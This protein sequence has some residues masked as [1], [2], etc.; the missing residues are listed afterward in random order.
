[1]LLGTEQAYA[2][3][4]ALNFLSKTATGGFFIITGAAGTGKSFLISRLYD[5]LAHAGAAVTVIAPTGKAA[6]NLREKNSNLR[7]MTLHSLLYYVEEVHT[8][9]LDDFGQ[10]VYAPD[11]TKITI[12]KRQFKKRDVDSIRSEVDMIIMDEASMLQLSNA[13][14]LAQLNIPVVLFGDKEQLPPFGEEDFSILS[15]TPDVHLIDVRRTTMDNAI[16]KLAYVIIETGS[17]FVHDYGHEVEFLSHEEFDVQFLKDNKVDAIL[18]H[19]NAKRKEANDMARAA[20]GLYRDDLPKLGETIMCL[21]NHSFPM[22]KNAYVYMSNGQ[23]VEC[24]QDAGDCGGKVRLYLPKNVVVTIDK[25]KFYED[26][27]YE[28]DDKHC[29]C[30]G[31]GL[32]VHK[33]QGS[34]FDAVAV[35]LPS[36]YVMTNY[37][38]NIKAWLYTAVTRAK[39]KLYV[40]GI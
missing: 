31:Y 36:D 3:L 6:T 34:E 1:M 28:D 5:T 14:F 21:R 30:F 25:D 33:A 4:G 38:D 22:G 17:L 8:P 2:L 15:K 13:K 37:M 39:K 11:G 40:V 19:S 23:T 35:I 26:A 32:T 12:I 9:K 7:A 27:P 20:K 24:V 18:S 10:Q 16:Y 29:F